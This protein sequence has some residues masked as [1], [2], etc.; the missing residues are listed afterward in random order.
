MD[1]VVLNC[2]AAAEHGN[3]PKTAKNRALHKAAEAETLALVERELA[4][5]DATAGALGGKHPPKETALVVDGATLAYCLTKG[6]QLRFLDLA[7]Q[8]KVG[9][10]T[11]SGR[12]MTTRR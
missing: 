12:A 4:K 9:R 5:L 11:A 1:L 10:F 8:C 3:K 7:V 6:N 2:A